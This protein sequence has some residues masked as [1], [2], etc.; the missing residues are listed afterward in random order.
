MVKSSHFEMET[1]AM[2]YESLLFMIVII[3]LP[4]NETIAIMALV[5][6][7]QLKVTHPILRIAN[8]YL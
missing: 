5:Y 8:K 3:A 6:S 7:L 2:L 4:S 1:C